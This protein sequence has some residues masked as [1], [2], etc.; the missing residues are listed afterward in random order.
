MA[1]IVLV[2][3]DE[4]LLHGQ[5]RITWGKY[6]GANTIIVAND[7]IASN[8][9]LQAP[10]KGAAGGEYVVL[11]RTIEHLISSIHKADERRRIL[12]LC[13]NPTDVARL[14]KGG[15]K[16]GEVNVGNMHHHPGR[17][18][19][20]KNVSVSVNDIEA[21]KIIKKNGIESYIQHM[22]ESSRKNIFD[23]V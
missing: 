23:C 10:F 16:F 20:D 11:F 8:P 5:I 21:F 3:I 18:Q 13:K 9:V 7:E 4:R 2:R 15:V 6:S 1:N 19:I 17:V 12:I 22:P 14:V